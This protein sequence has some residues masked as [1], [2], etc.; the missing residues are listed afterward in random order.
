MGHEAPLTWSSGEEHY[1]QA[2]VGS[3]AYNDTRLTNLM[4]LNVE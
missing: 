3:I 4:I 2:L 1:F